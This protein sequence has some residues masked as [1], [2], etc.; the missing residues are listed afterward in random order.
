[1]KKYG[2]MSL[3]FSVQKSTSHIAFLIIFAKKFTMD[4]ISGNDSTTT[5][6]RFTLHI[7]R[8][9]W[10]SHVFSQPIY[11][12]G[13]LIYK[14]GGWE[15]GFSTEVTEGKHTILIKKFI[16]QAKKEIDIHGEMTVIYKDRDTW[17]QLLV[18]AAILLQIIF[19]LIYLTFH[20]RYIPIDI[21]SMVVAVIV[22]VWLA[23]CLLH[24][25]NF[26]K[27]QITSQDFQNPA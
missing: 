9:T 24:L 20:P 1:M 26:Y 22:I 10:K 3:G 13:K 18:F 25:R 23:Y 7:R 14:Y 6:K 5:G 16:F 2:I 27:F 4:T 19:D 17:C 8:E 21:F 15:T 11:L 12:D